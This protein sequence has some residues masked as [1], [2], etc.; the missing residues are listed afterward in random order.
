MPGKPNISFFKEE[1]HG[2][3][4]QGL[5]EDLIIS[6]Q[7]LTVYPYQLKQSLSIETGKGLLNGFF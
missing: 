7:Y 2:L 1:R 5:S 3:K 4:Y 6:C